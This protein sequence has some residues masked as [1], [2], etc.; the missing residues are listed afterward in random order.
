MKAKFLNIL[1]IA[2]SLVGYLE[3]GET[4][5]SFLFQVEG[6]VLFKLFTD[7][8]SIIHPLT[9]LPVLGQILLAVT[10]FQKT[11][12]KVLTYMALEA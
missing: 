2:T 8:L 12:G 10:L 9:I 4:H 5:H 1:L 11:R 7:P 3:C 6:E